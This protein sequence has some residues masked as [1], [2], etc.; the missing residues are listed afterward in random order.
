MILDD[1]AYHY[2]LTT[3]A[4]AEVAAEYREIWNGIFDS[5]GLA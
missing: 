4:D 5:F 3:M 1:G 2:V